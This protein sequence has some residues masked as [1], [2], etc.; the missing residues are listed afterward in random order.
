[1]F[2]L[3][4]GIFLCEKRFVRPQQ[5]SRTQ[6]RQVPTASALQAKT[7]FWIRICQPM[8]ATPPVRETA[9]SACRRFGGQLASKPLPANTM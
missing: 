5:S 4:I 9:I 6:P 1:M 7:S 8:T 2:S 3:F